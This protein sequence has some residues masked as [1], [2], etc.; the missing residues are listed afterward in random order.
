MPKKAEKIAFSSGFWKNSDKICFFLAMKNML[1]IVFLSILLLGMGVF[2]MPQEWK[3]KIPSTGLRDFLLARDI[4]YGLDLAGGSQLDFLVD[5]SRVDE[6]IAAGEDINKDSIIDGVKSTL[7]KRI[8]PDGTREL[9]IYPADFGDEK[10]IFVELTADIDTPETRAKL[11]K[12]IDLQFKEPKSGTD[13]EEKNAAE[14]AA[15]FTLNQIINGTDFIE[16]GKSAE[17]N[18]ETLRITLEEGATRFRDELSDDLAEKIWNASPGLIAEVLPSEGSYTIDPFSNQL[19]QTTAFSIFSIQEKKDAPKKTT[20]P[21]EDFGSVA[22]EVQG[23][24][25]IRPIA[26]L[27]E[28]T[29]KEILKTTQPNAI[30]DVFEINGQFAVFKL[31]AATED[32]GGAR[33]SEIQVATQE[34]AESIKARVG[35]QTEETM[36]PQIIFDEIKFEA[37]PG[38]W[39]ETGLDGRFFKSAKVGQSQTGMPVTLIQFTD[40]GSQKF[41]ELTK[42]LVGQPM[43]IFVGGEFISAPVIQEEITGGSAQISF[44][45]QNYSESRKEATNL[46]RDLKAGAIPAPISPAG[47]LR[48]APSLGSEALSL[49][50]QAG[51][52]GVLLLSL[53]MLFQYRLLGVVA[54][55]ALGFYGVFFLAFIK[56]FSGIVLTLA[57]IAGVLLSLGMA[58]DANVLIFERVREELRAGR[59]FAASL[60]I[61]FDR[62]WTAIRDGNLTTIIICFILMFLGT[63][64]VKGFATMLAIGVLLSMFTAIFVT[65]TILALF[66]GKNFTKKTALFMKT[67]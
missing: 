2:A 4:H 12:H 46:A 3:E 34:A 57:G 18:T 53:F 11:Q 9:N 35:E 36:E 41:A 32:S 50:L 40:E 62:A 31:L 51:A 16:A 52:V 28:E 1:R 61:G 23:E 64:I 45:V 47:E 7:Q 30:S 27:A 17:K 43:A 22:E 19:T 26:E 24:E 65:K 49:S 37:V 67:K 55:V 56:I 39:K 66:I 21:G 13:E 60:S 5:M 8:D 42:R 25:K 15:N 10:H 14:S 48:I 20:V 33:V 44:G 54:I 29:K 58:V 59:T 63:S 6:R 38:I